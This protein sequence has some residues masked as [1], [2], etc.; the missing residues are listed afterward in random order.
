M[1]SFRA[2][3]VSDLRL[4]STGC[5][6]GSRPF[7]LPSVDSDSP[8]SSSPSSASPVWS[9]DSS[10]SDSP[11]SS[12]G[13]SALAFLASSFFFSKS[14][15]E[16]AYTSLAKSIT[17]WIVSVRSARSIN[18]FSSRVKVTPQAIPALK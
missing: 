15:L 1:L 6:A 7:E 17:S 3:S 18:T 16:K 2:V 11:S 5:S 8:S 9:S 14:S 10:S 4:S 12:S 13:S